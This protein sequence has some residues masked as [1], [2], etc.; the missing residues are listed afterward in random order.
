M[1]IYFCGRE[2]L[3]DNFW[4]VIFIIGLLFVCIGFLCCVVFVG[5]CFVVGVVGIVGIGGLVVGGCRLVC[6]G[7]CCLFVVG[8]WC[9]GGLVGVFRVGVSRLLFVLFV[10]GFVGWLCV[11]GGWF[12]LVLGGRL[13]FG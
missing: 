2:L 4:R 10:V 5:F 3:F 6:C 11:C 8:C 1:G 7:R 13:G 12:G 9:L